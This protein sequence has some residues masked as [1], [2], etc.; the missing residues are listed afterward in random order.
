MKRRVSVAV[1]SVLL[2]RTLSFA[3]VTGV[4]WDQASFDAAPEVVGQPT[5]AVTFDLFE[6]MTTAAD[7]WHALCPQGQ[8]TCQH[9]FGEVEAIS[10]ALY[11]PDEGSWQA[12]LGIFTRDDPAFPTHALAPIAGFSGFGEFELSMF[13]PF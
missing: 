11:Q 3:E 9:D 13:T 4:Y 1:L 7:S 10:T 6:A 12:N 2:A 5:T 8:A